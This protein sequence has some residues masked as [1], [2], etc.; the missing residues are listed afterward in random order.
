MKEEKSGTCCHDVKPM[1]SS[2][3]N[4]AQVLYVCPMHPEIRQ[5][6]PGSCP[7][8]GMALEPE[9][10]STEEVV[11]PEYLEMK[12][13][14]WL[15]FIL[16]L[17]I[18]VLEMVGH[19][20]SIHFIDAK[21][22]NW[23]Q[24]LLATPV[25]FWCGWPFFQ[26]GFNS[27]ITRQLNMFTLIAMGV[28]VA[29]SYSVV[30]VLFPELFPL[31]FRDS[32]GLVA[33]YFEAAA[34]ITVLVLLGQ[35]L[36][37]KAREQT[38]SSI[39]ALLNLVPESAH[40]IT[41][42]DQ[43]EIVSLDKIQVGDLLRV[44][45]GEKV[46]VDGEVQEGHSYVDESMVTGEPMPVV[47]TKGA[48]V[49]GATINQTGSFVM[50]AQRVGHDTMLS[51][52]VQMV[53]AAQRSRAPIQRL[54][55]KVSGWF[56]P[57]VVL[58][59]L[60]AFIIWAII[61]PQPAFSYG[62]I[63]AVSVLIIACPC[64]LGLA[65]PMSIMIGVGQGARHGVLIKNAQALE[66]MEKVNALIVDKTGTLTEGH[67]KL[68]HVFTREGFVEEEILAL[69][70]AIEKQ[71]EHPLSKAI[72]MEAEK[73][74]L[75]LAFVED[76]QSLTGLGVVGKINGRFIAI[77]NLRLMQTYQVDSSFFHEKADELRAK[78]ASVMFVAVD[79]QVAAILVVD[80][81]IKVST[82]KAIQ[83]LQNKGIK[84]IMVTGDNQKTA[85]AVA[86]LLGIEQVVAE[87]MPQDKSRTIKELKAQGFVVA[88]AGD[89]VND[90]PALALADVG[91]AMGTGTD[92]AI[93]SAG[94]TLLHG[95][96]NGIVKAR[97]L[98]E[99]TMSNIR[100]NLFFAFIYNGLGVPLAAGL[101]YP[102][103]GLLLSPIVAAA[104][105]SLSSVCVI[106]N[107]L[108]LRRVRL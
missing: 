32:K 9:Q 84:V 69:S 31:A 35:V 65:T 74:G 49:I 22:S 72:V 82:P 5:P 99:A 51:H 11:N 61:G 60:V 44:R 76:F 40:L 50:K 19:L 94:I 67:P 57:L 97:H 54:A 81:P 12:Q 4:G 78:G 96:L 24:M 80:D 21:L 55:D 91:I 68:T 86:A 64:A 6:L 37:L 26:R 102:F 70:A 45:P 108:R 47:K 62:L 3:A 41:S 15:A 105:M 66:T 27:L 33:I 34:V 104:A 100:Q 101:F 79:N 93:E 20:F 39:R 48:Q 52:I 87:V 36:E 13:R 17:P 83:E 16:I 28:G 38:G 63:A 89:G 46:P 25:V 18:V 75:K 42:N 90:A 106:L 88:M 1:K 10:I 107:A 58:I 53:T 92:V 8:C 23:I 30:A 73:Q 98:S 29:W 77:G 7:L 71:S 2:I 85:A 56:V 14:F 95:D 43:E 103:T 59:A